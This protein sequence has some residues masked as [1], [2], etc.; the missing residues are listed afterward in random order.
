[1]EDPRSFTIK[2]P[3]LRMIASIFMGVAYESVGF[4]RDAGMA[5]AQGFMLDRSKHYV[6]FN[7]FA[8]LR[9]HDERV[10]VLVRGAPGSGKNTFANKMAE[11]KYPVFSADDFFMEGGQYNFDP[12]QLGAAHKFA[13]DETHNAMKNKAPKIFVANTFVRSNELVPYYRMAGEHDYK[14]FSVVVENRHKGISI[15]EVPDDVIQRMRNDFD[16][17]L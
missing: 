12:R 5:K 16:V 11:D 15:H 8:I 14:V 4:I 10:L 17:K 13:Q 7:H 2:N 3:A 6:P 9:R 1:M